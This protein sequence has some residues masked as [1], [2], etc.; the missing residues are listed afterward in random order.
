MF[1]GN[2]SNFIFSSTAAVYGNKAL[3]NKID[4]NSVTEPK[5]IL[6]D[7]QNC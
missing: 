4:E 7:I 1:E 2:I 5:K 3:Q 6:M